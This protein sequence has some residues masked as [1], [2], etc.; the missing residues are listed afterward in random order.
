MAE[1]STGF[2]G[3]LKD[4][5]G[6]MRE[7]AIVAIFGALLL[8]P[9][10]VAQHLKDAGFTRGNIGG[11]EWEAEQV[12]AA[13]EQAIEGVK[14]LG[15]VESSLAQVQRSLTA[16]NTRVADPT[17][18]QE[19]QALSAKIGTSIR[20]AKTARKDLEASQEK[21]SNVMRRLPPDAPSPIRRDTETP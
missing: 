18:Q 14:K 21:L 12:R 2:L 7:L 6:A 1:A 15:E 17:S 9:S 11:W 10:S 4:F 13:R 8:A 3:K 20:T 19:F 5:T 16:L